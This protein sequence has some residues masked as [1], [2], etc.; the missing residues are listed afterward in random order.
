MSRRNNDTVTIP[1]ETKT[2]EFDGKLWLGL[3]LVDQGKTA[4]LGPAGEIKQTL[5]VTQPNIHITKDPGDGKLNFFDQ[6]REA[7]I[8]ICGL[9]TEGAVFDSMAHFAA[10]KSKFLDHIDAFCAWGEKPAE[11]VRQE[12]AD[13]DKIHVTGNPRFDLQPYLRPIY[14]DRSSS[15]NNQ[16]GDY[17]LINCNF[18]IANPHQGTNRVVRTLEQGRRSFIHRIFHLFNEA[19]YHLHSE[20]PGINIIVRPHPSESNATYEAAFSEYDHIHVEDTGDVRNWIAGA[21]VVLH[22]DC[23]TGIESAL[24][25]TPVVS[26]RPIQNEEYEARLP[27]IVSYE[28]SSREELT[29]LIPDSLESD[30]VYEMDAEQ[31]YKLKQYFHNVDVSAAE[32]ICD[33]IDSLETDRPRN[34][35]LLK[36]SLIGS[37]KRQIRASDWSDQAIRIYDSIHRV[38]G[39]NEIPERREYKNKKFPGLGRDELLKRIEQMKPLLDIDDISV[40]Q[41][42]LTN[43]TYY[44]RPV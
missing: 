1:I 14:H 13:T 43:D 15:I 27:Q 38:L 22:H 29:A 20:F 37:L 21:N 40:E 8:S 42:P 2:R 4:V 39:D 44:L 30:G 7:G 10:G 12:F 19:T 16:Y 11:A 33:V 36:H 3:N 28:A 35:E 6:L 5:D 9:D 32:L 26:Y 41:V 24:M 18:G 31:T 17:I 34:Y 25:G 23:T